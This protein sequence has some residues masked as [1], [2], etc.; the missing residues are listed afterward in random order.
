MSR[1][2]SGSSYIL[3][4]STDWDDYIAVPVF[5]SRMFRHSGIYVR[6]DAGI[7][8]PEDLNGRDVGI[9]GICHDGSVMDSRGF[10]RT[11]MA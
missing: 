5:P 10:C 1:S 8:S 4:K 2:L 6:K 9:P 3:A 7:L 11:T